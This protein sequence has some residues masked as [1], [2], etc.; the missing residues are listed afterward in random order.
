MLA[1][2][3]LC[4]FDAVGDTFAARLDVFLRDRANYIDLGWKRGLADDLVEMAR[5]LTQGTWQ[6]RAEYD[7]L[8]TEHVVG[9]S[10]QRMQP[11]DRN[12]LRLG[13]YEL[14]ECADT[15]PAVVLN[16]AI[17]L[18]RLFG[19]ADS[20][21]FVNGVLDGLRRKLGID[22]TARPTGVSEVCEESDGSV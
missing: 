5:R 17:E 20:P 6:H 1:L 16:E 15:P 18:A 13:L 14:Q 22:V 4:L 12:I 3:A 19:G 7:A 21:G 11:V 9:W 10:V 2:Q 8:L